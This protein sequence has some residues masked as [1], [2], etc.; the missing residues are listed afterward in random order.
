MEDYN[1]EFAHIYADKGFGK[2]QLESVSRLKEVIKELKKKKRTFQTVIL[3]DEY[4][5]T[6]CTLDEQKFL[7]KVSAQGVNPD[8]VA[9]ES[10]LTD[11]AGRIIGIIP[12]EL[13]K[14]QRFGKREVTLLVVGGKRIGLYEDTGRYTCAMLIAAWTLVRFGVYEMP[15]SK[16]NFRAHWSTSE[17]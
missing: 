17:Y 11:I 9:H 2:E 3:I 4:S 13:L 7:E 15:S 6:S 16:K 1:I 5:P 10:D 14:R 8:F 12:K